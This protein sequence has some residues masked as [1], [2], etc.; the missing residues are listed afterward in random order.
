NRSAVRPRIVF[1]ASHLLS[2]AIAS[3]GDILFCEL[4]ARIARHRPD[5]RVTALAPEFAVP[6]LR[7]YFDD[8][9][10]FPASG[11]AKQGSPRDVALSWA[12]RLGPA[13]T[14][15]EKLRPTIIHTTGD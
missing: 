3:G 5:W 1:V 15:L 6:A 4:A 2:P 12:R 9:E 10:A 8:I 13:R 11:N 14:H 7:K